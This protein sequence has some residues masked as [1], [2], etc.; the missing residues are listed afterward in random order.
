MS[1]LHVA[2]LCGALLALF[3][4][5][6]VLK[7]LPH[8]LIPEG[9]AKGPVESMEDMAEF[10]ISGGMPVFADSLTDVEERTA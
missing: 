10:G 8:S 7:Y 5:F 1:G 2:A 6:I 9:A 4:G 3:A